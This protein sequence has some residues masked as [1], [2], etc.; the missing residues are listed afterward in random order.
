MDVTDAVNQRI[1]E[2]Y[3]DDLSKWDPSSAEMIDWKKDYPDMGVIFGMPQ[4]GDTQGG[5]GGT[6]FL[7][8]DEDDDK[9]MIDGIRTEDDGQDTESEDEGNEPEPEPGSK[10]EAEIKPVP[11]DDFDFDLEQY[12]DVDFDD[13]FSIL[14]VDDGPGK[15]DQPLGITEQSSTHIEGSDSKPAAEEQQSEEERLRIEFDELLPYYGIP[16]GTF[17]EEFWAEMQLLIAAELCREIRF[18]VKD[19]LGY[20]CSAGIANNRLLA[21]VGSG[22]NKPFQQVTARRS[23]VELTVCSVGFQD[24]HSPIARSSRQLS[25]PSIYPIYCMDLRSAR[26]ATWEGNSESKCERTLALNERLSCGQR[27]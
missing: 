5:I 27:H 15:D 24:S 1:M 8:D 20:T 9:S 21:K 22:M 19:E 16:E 26:Y 6:S 4:D 2:K 12:Q 11:E 18:A 13:S 3:G 7:D 25:Y 17:E 10:Y 14:H 23:L